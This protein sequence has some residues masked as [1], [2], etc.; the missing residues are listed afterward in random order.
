MLTRTDSLVVETLYGELLAVLGSLAL[1]MDELYAA[2]RD[3]QRA[4]VS[5]DL[6]G[7][8][9]AVHGQG[10]LVRL[11]HELEEK[12]RELCRRISGL[13]DPPPV[14]KL[15]EGFGE[16]GRTQLK[17][18]ARRVRESAGRVESLKSQNSFLLERA[19]SLVSGQLQLMLELTRINRNVY[20]ESGK[21]SRKANLVKV[22]DKKI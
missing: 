22:F 10:R 17:E 2:L 9:A 5:R 6:Q 12:R 3:Q 13:S 4:V 16:P 8:G 19:R 18:A 21:K 15:A 20:E 14:S 11:I 1:Q 7:L